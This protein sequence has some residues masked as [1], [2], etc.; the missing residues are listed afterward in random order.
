MEGKRLYDSM[1]QTWWLDGMYSDPI[2]FPRSRP[3]CLT[4]NDSGRCRPPPLGPILVSRPLGWYSSDEN[5]HVVVVRDYLT[6]WPM[7]FLAADQKTQQI[8]DLLVKE[9]VPFY[10]VPE[11]LLSDHGASHLMHDV[12]EAMGIKKPNTTAYRS[13][14]DG[15]VER[16]NRTLKAMFCKQ[17]A[18]YGKEWDRHLYG[19]LWANWNTPHEATR[20]KPSFLFFGTDLRSPAEAELLPVTERTDTKAETYRE[21]LVHTLATTRAL[22]EKTIRQDLV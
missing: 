21:R 4:V 11:C 17:A 8:V 22:A 3:E 14:C 18:R 7:V 16:L 19:V 13:Q 5:K 12:C 2:K 6:K 9:L 10:G 1:A 20:E 15:M